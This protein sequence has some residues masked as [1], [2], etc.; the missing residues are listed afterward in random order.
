[1]ETIN[2]WGCRCVLGFNAD[3]DAVVKRECEE[4]KAKG[5]QKP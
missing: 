2:C 4:C 5:E 1:M 3:G